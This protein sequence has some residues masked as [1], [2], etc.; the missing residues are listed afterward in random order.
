MKDAIEKSKKKDNEE[1]NNTSFISESSGASTNSREI[2]EFQISL[3]SNIIRG[4]GEA[5]TS[6][7]GISHPVD[8]IGKTKSVGL[9]MP[10]IEIKIVDVNDY[11]K[12][13]P[14]GESGEILLKGHSIMKGYWNKPEQTSKQMKDGWFFTGNVGRMD[15]DGY[16]YIIDKIQR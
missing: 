16:V 7:L 6:A 3:C 8:R 5:E 11:N 13:M 4:Y 12:I 14:L 1:W 10:N 2:L 15:E 9:P